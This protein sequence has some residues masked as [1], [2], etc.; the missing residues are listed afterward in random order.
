MAKPHHHLGDDFDQILEE[1][2]VYKSY[3]LYKERRFSKL[4]YSAGAIYDC[5]SQFQKLLDRTHLN[6]L[7][8][9]AC[10]LYLESDYIKTA[11]RALSNFTFCVTMPFLN[12]VERCNQNQLIEII[13]SLHS[14]LENKILRSTSLEPYHVPWKH[15]DMDKQKPVTNL[16]KFILDEM[17]LKAA[18]GIELQCSREY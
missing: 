11:L 3:S 6:S 13:P 4:G 15:V 10:R 7:L 17:C 9:R 18:A 1:D 2:S 5:L 8:V 12:C 14:D 16:D